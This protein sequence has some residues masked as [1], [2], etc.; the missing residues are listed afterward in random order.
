MAGYSISPHLTQ[1]SSSPP[2]SSP[3]LSTPRR[4]SRISPASP[5]D[6]SA[7]PEA[8][9]VRED[10]PEL[11]SRASQLSLIPLSTNV[12]SPKAD[13]G[14]ARRA[15]GRWY[16]PLLIQQQ[17]SSVSSVAHSDSSGAPYPLPITPADEP[18]HY[19]PAEEKFRC[20]EFPWSHNPLPFNSHPASSGAPAPL[21]AL[22]R[23][24]VIPHDPSQ[25]TLALPTSSS[26]PDLTATSREHP[27]YPAAWVPQGAAAGGC[28][29]RCEEMAISENSPEDDAANV[30]AVLAYTGRRGRRTG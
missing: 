24:P 4:K 15:A 8:Q 1:A 27:R 25:R 23:A 13:A 30:L 3:P 21:P 29:E 22:E 5:V 18:W 12:V 16:P 9:H 26:P 2:T 19:V 14:L 7:I 10:F 6:G 11:R 17:S 20:S 28:L